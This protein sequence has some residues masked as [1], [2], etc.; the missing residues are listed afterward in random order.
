[1]IK[2]E[3]IGIVEAKY[4]TTALEVIDIMCKQCQVELLCTEKYL[5]GRLVST[6][7][8]GD[9]SN[10]KEAIDLVKSKYNYDNSM[11]KNAIVITRPHQNI[12]KF[13]VKDINN[14]EVIKEKNTI[15]KTEDFKNK[16]S[17]KE[18]S[19]ENNKDVIKVE[20][21]SKI[22]KENNNEVIDNVENKIN[23]KTAN[24]ANKNKNKKKIKSSKKSKKNDK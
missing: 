24:E 8:S 3:A 12:M 15:E 16:E 23:D 5:G 7:V 2:Y 1:M 19:K 4:F 18:D 14:N 10:V 6:I 22:V 17:I 9:I 20:N 21:I 11:L 13:I